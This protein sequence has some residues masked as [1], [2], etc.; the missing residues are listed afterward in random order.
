M[1]IEMHGLLMV[2]DDDPVEVDDVDM[3]FEG[4]HA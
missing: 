2:V 1:S 3:W 4:E